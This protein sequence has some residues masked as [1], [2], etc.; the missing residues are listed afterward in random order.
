M[1]LLIAI[2]HILGS[3][4]V[5]VLLWLF[6]MQI[7][8]WEVQ[9]TKKRKSE[10]IALSLGITIDELNDEAIAPRIF[11]YASERY[12]NELLRNRLS[13]FVGTIIAAW[14]WLGFIAQLCTLAGVIWNSINNGADN[15]VFAWSVVGIGVIFMLTSVFVSLGCRL[16]TGRYPCEAKQTR[17]ALVEVL[18]ARVKS[19]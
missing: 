3:I 1:L 18:A 14:G 15:A 2:G 5:M 17:K 12:S 4:V 11:Q 8:A 13:D 16:L 6:V 9:R 10:E 7:T 19:T